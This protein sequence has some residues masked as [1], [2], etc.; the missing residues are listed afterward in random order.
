[1]CNAYPP[2]WRYNRSRRG[3]PEGYLF[4]AIPTGPKQDFS[5]STAKA[6]E[7]RDNDTAPEFII[8][9]TGTGRHER[10]RQQFQTL[11]S[12]NSQPI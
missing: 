6:P 10:D 4:P 9:R 2:I 5:A 11:D 1:M 8:D 7:I 12:V 3:K